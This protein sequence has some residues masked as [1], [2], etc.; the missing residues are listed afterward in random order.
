MLNAMNASNKS[1]LVGLETWS[2]Q[3]AAGVT[4]R[5]ADVASR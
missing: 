2:G 1:H 5:T 3:H 4:G